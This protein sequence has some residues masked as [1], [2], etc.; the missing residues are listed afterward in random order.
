MKVRFYD[1]NR[2]DSILYKIGIGLI[3]VMGLA[4][5][6]GTLCPPEHSQTVTGGV[7]LIAMVLAI[8]IG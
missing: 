3:V 5:F 4:I 6:A 1:R 8:F 2:K 7:A